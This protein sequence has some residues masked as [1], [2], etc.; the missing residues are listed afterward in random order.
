MP[1]TVFDCKGIP[2]T[3]RERI[4]AAVEAAGKSQIEPYEAW[5]SADPFRGGVRVSIMGPHGFQTDGQSRRRRRS[6]GDPRARSGD[7][8]GRVAPALR[9]AGRWS[10]RGKRCRSQADQEGSSEINSGR[11]AAPRR[12]GELCSVDGD[13]VPTTPFPASVRVGA[14]RQYGLFPD[15]LSSGKIGRIVRLLHSLR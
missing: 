4:E 8:G 2:A 3:R 10:E 6:G 14:K 11:A 15:A 13:L 7:A 1:L 9:G 5:I 12:H